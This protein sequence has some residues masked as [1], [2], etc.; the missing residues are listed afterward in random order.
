MYVC[1]YARE[2]LWMYLLD[3][4][5]VSICL[6]VCVCVRECMLWFGLVLWNIKHCRL[7]NAKFFLHI[8]IKYIRFGLVG[9]NGISI[10]VGYL[11]PNRLH[12]YIYNFVSFRLMV[13][14]TL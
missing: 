11:M 6:C 9:F 12:I 7:F 14:Q 8:Y 3:C 2:Y 1:M 13:Y 10:I 5:C 4:A